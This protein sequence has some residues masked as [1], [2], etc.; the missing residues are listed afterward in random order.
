MPNI[1]G[2]DV[3]GLRERVGALSQVVRVDEFV[4]AN[5]SNAGSRLIRAINGGGL[6][7]EI[8]P[9][10]ALDLGQVTVDGV[11]IAW[12][13]PA[14][15]VGP[16]AAEPAGQGWLRT[17]GGGLL[18]TCGLDHFGPPV[19]DEGEALGQHGRIG[20]ERA[21]VTRA[22][23]SDDG[24]V[25]EGEVR[26]AKV[27]GEHLVLRRRISSQAGSDAILIEDRV[28][29]ES[30]REQPHMVLYHLNLGW[31]LLGDETTIDVP[32]VQVTPRDSDAAAGIDEHA[33]FGAPVADYREQVFAHELAEGTS[34][35]RVSNPDNGLSF[36]LEVDQAQLPC[37]FQ[38]KMQGQGHYALGIEPAN[39]PNLFGRA[40]ARAA[41]E[42]PMLAPGESVSYRLAIRLR[43]EHVPGKHTHPTQQREEA[44]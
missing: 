44:A 31:P 21:S 7:F 40:A 41:G 20:T 30:F 6:E 18:A 36:E 22:I 38:W 11:P 35:V 29:N 1:F 19:V 34:R 5:G 25:I 15:K 33:R 16:G 10:R 12:T 24:V 14:G 3:A 39:T 37:I 13:S 23:A 26:Q 4:E 17:F 9:D 27:F 2:A 28:T 43:R 32:A 8:F 42:L